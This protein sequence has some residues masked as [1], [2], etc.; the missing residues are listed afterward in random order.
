MTFLESSAKVN[1][2]RSRI[3]MPRIN[4]LVFVFFCSL[5]KME[6]E[7][8]QKMAVEEKWNKVIQLYGVVYGVV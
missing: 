1:T 3:N 7:S 5:K 2:S 4:K 8:Y 6:R